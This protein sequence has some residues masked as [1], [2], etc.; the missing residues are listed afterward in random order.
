MTAARFSSQQLTLGLTNRQLADKLNCD[1][2]SVSKWKRRQTT[3]PEY[4]A[5]YLDLLVYV[6]QNEVEVTFTLGELMALSARA[7]SLGLSVNEYLVDLV[8]ADIASSTPPPDQVPDQSPDG[9]SVP[10]DY[11]AIG[12]EFLTM[13]AA[14]ESKPYK[15]KRPAHKP[16]LNNPA[17]ED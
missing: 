12:S 14:E 7:H 5:G 15:T 8:R 16:T 17:T 6:H 2:G 3:I 10:V 1:E 13:K 11:T 9:A 4:I